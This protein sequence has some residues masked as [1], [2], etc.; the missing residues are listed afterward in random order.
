MVKE[1][2]IA[3][4][5]TTYLQCSRWYRNGK[6]QKLLPTHHQDRYLIIKKSMKNVVY[7]FPVPGWKLTRIK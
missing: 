3:V 6:R 2:A 7:E 5:T 4:P 1:P